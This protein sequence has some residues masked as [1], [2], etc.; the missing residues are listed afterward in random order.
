[1]PRLSNLARRKLLLF[2]TIGLFVGACSP[3]ASAPP[4]VPATVVASQ[5]SAVPTSQA[6]TAPAPTAAPPTTPPTLVPTA[7]PQP[8]VPPTNTPE[9]TIEPTPAVRPFNPE[10]AT[11]LQQILDQTVAD[12][13]IPG[14]VVAVHIA[15]QEPWIGASGLADRAS[16]T[17]MTTA[18]RLRIASISKTFTAATVLQLVEEGK[19]DLNAPIST[20]LPKVLPNGNTITVRNLLQHTTGLYDYLE[21]RRYVSLVYSQPDRIFAPQELVNFA[22]E[23]PPL[24]APNAPGKWDY[25]STNFVILG[26]LVEQTTG[27]PLAKVMRARIFEPLG[28]SNTF[29]APDETIE[30]QASGYFKDANYTRAAMSFG[31]ATANLVSNPADVV[32]FGDALFA[33]KLF[34]NPETLAE[35]ETFVSGQGQYNMPDLEY[36]LGLMRNVLPV[37][38]AA[39]TSRV[40]GHIGGFG[41]F[42]SALWSSPQQ[43]ITI[44]LG[45]NQGSTDPNTLAAKVWDAILTSQGR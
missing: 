34:T 43:G 19:I 7:T 35:M 14:A 22:L 28:L 26:M 36:G 20:Y 8:T 2:C 10:L 30:G 16:G 23:N 37:G 24:F 32:K 3:T 18:T 13:Y 42:R 4:A 29:F 41:G 44:A 33:G 12:G 9:P 1:M 38:R 11:R 6:T 21:D 25:S 5:P 17:P 15:G 31:F 39:S 45:V 27:E 40:M